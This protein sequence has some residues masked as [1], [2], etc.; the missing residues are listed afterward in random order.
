MDYC[1]PAGTGPHPIAIVIHGGGFVRAH[2]DTQWSARNRK[3]AQSARRAGLGEVDDRG[4]SFFAMDLADVQS[5]ESAA[6][7]IGR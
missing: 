4:Q 3:L 7:A 1:S 6:A 5:K 2:R